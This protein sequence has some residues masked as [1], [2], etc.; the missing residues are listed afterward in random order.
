MGNHEAQ[1]TN[2][3]ATGGVC[4]FL[5]GPDIPLRTSGPD[6]GHVRLDCRSAAGGS[7]PLCVDGSQECHKRARKAAPEHVGCLTQTLKDSRFLYFDYQLLVTAFCVMRETWWSLL[8]M[9]RTVEF[10]W[11]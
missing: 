10:G 11:P 3:F 9:L 6:F 2:C 8:Y 4:T 7:E 5:P 1:L